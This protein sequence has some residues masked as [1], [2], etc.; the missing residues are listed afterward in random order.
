MKRV[1]ASLGLVLCLLCGSAELYAQS[2]DLAPIVNDLVGVTITPPAGWEEFK[3][4]G[5]D[6][7]IAAFRH[8]E[9]QSQIEIIAT[10]LISAD[11][12]QVYF[13]TFTQ[14]LSSYEFQEV[15]ASTPVSFGS[16]SGTQ[17]EYEYNAGITKVRL[18]VVSFLQKDVAYLVVGYFGVPEREQYYPALKTTIEK[19]VF[20]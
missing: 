7:S 2:G 10:K 14:S 5:N 4:T 8:A 20:N 1:S 13:D 9:S 12:A 16:I 6:K 18:V 11:V 19:L 17:V 3:V 15:A